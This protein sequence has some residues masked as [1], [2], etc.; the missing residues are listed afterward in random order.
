M[1]ISSQIKQARLDKGWSIETLA[2]EVRK[3]AGGSEA[4]IVTEWW[5]Q[6]INAI[7]NDGFAEMHHVDYCFQALEIKI[8]KKN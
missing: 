4:P 8:V 2:D 7:E 5:L 3:I 1:N 6:K